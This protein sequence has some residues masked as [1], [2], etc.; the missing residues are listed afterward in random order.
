MSSSPL[1]RTPLYEEHRACEARMVPFAGWEMPVQYTSILQEVRAVRT[2]VGLF[3]ITHM[4][5]VLL[6]G[7][8]AEKLLQG[9]TTNDVASL[10]P[11]RAHYS[12]LTNPQGGILDDIIVYRIGPEEF[13]VVVNA[14]NRERD[15]EWMRA[16]APGTVTIEDQSAR[17]A[18]IAVQGPAAIALVEGLSPAPLAGLERF[19]WTEGQVAGVHA[20]LCRTGYTGEDGLELIVPAEAAAPVWRALVGGGGVPCGLGAR[21]ALRIEAGYPLYGHEI[22]DS[23]TPV[24]A[25]LLWAVSLEKGDFIGRDRIVAVREQG[26]SRRLVGLTVAG[27]IPPRQ[28]Y[29]LFAGGEAVGQVTSGVFSP[30]VQ[31]GL[32]MAYVAPP[33]HRRGSRLEMEVRGSRHQVTVVPKKELLPDRRA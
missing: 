30:T 6:R 28:G 7:S 31:H 21:D 2:G 15:L 20:V 14:S 5:R 13:R 25:G 27:K 10:A 11:G 32:G 3:D 19:A 33:H 12:L 23:T 24:E 29:T 4:G 16:H 26:P 8:G 9:I 22:D 17:T 18:M 1:L